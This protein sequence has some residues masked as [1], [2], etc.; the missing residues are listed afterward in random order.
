MG[1][2]LCGKKQAPPAAPPVELSEFDHVVIERVQLKN[3]V[4]ALDQQLENVGE[5]IKKTNPFG[6][7]LEEI[8][9]YMEK[10]N[11]S[12]SHGLDRNLRDKFSGRP[13]RQTHPRKDYY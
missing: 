1:L 9:C 11:S 4:A 7:T 6:L 12:S 10:K 2:L 5:F 8:L 13:P 3:K